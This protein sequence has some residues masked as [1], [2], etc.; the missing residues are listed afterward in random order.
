MRMSW[1]CRSRRRT[2]RPSRTP[3]GLPYVDPSRHLI[4]RFPIFP[5]ER[6]G[7]PFGWIEV[8]PNRVAAVANA[9]LTCCP[10]G[11]NLARNGKPAEDVVA[12][13]ERARAPEAEEYVATPW[14]RC[15]R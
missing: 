11:P 3:A 9:H 14:R 10:Y 1:A 7:I 8:A 2:S 5:G 15:T 4:S 6:D 13:E 12:M